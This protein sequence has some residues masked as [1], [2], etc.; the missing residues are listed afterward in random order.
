ML[1]APQTEITEHDVERG[2]RGLVMDAAFASAVGQ[3]H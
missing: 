1:L 2:V 3:P